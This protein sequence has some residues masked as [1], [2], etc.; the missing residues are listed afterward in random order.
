[1]M[2]FGLAGINAGKNIDATAKTTTG[3]YVGAGAEAV[4]SM[5]GGGANTLKKAVM[6]LTSAFGS[7][8][9]A[10]AGGALANTVAPDSQAAKFVT[11]LLGAVLGGSAGLVG[12][13]PKINDLSPGGTRILKGAVGKG[14]ELS[15]YA[16]EAMVLEASPGATSLGRDL[17]VRPGPAQETLMDALRRRDAG[18]S[19]RLLGEVEAQL[20]KSTDLGVLKNQVEGST[21]VATHPLYREAYKKAP[22]FT[23]KSY[24][25]FADHLTN[26]TKSLPESERRAMRRQLPDVRDAMGIVYDK[27]TG[28]YVS[29]PNVPP[30]LQAERL[31]SIRQQ[32]DG[33]IAHTAAER[34]R[35]TNADKQTQRALKETRRDVDGLLKEIS[36]MAEADLAHEAGAIQSSSLTY[37]N[38]V[39]RDPQVSPGGL[40]AALEARTPTGLPRIDMDMARR[41]SLADIASRMGH[42]SA[43][44]DLSTLSRHFGGSQDFTRQKL[45]KLHG[46]AP[47]EAIA[48]RVGTEKRARQTLQEVGGGS[49]TAMRT[50]GSRALD[51][52][53]VGSLKSTLPEQNVS[54]LGLIRYVA[55]QLSRLG[56]SQKTRA[57]LAKEL[58][59]SGPAARELVD[60][61]KKLK[62]PSLMEYLARNAVIANTN[63]GGPR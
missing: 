58:V 33:S 43:E 6:E 32:L 46:A 56:T 14:D 59:K 7:G 2:D 41:G 17:A 8:V 47:I 5:L 19:D 28:A 24:T 1:M 18:T 63:A 16:D 9:G 37:G 61:V 15:K 21:T 13:R 57:N 62:G 23:P 44:G 27:K 26:T 38:E 50:A 42:N 40:T 54:P 34:S 36:G 60:K 20:G 48:K 49:Q 52:N 35:L 45:E 55:D 53:M 10:E 4:P 3:R 29:D 31:H 51:E 22:G 25:D 30:A 11:S 39:V 12:Q